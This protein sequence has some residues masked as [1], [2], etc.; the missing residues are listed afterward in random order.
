MGL[1]RRAFGS[2]G[3]NAQKLPRESYTKSY[4]GGESTRKMLL[5]FDMLAGGTQ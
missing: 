5:S 3:M 4:S 2:M 1:C